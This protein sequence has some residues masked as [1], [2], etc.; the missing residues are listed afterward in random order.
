M[1]LNAKL[2]Q[3]VAKNYAK[4]LEE[5]DSCDVSIT[6]GS[7]DDIKTFNV[8]S[9]ILRTQTPYFHTA[10]SAQWGKKKGDKIVLS[11]PNVTPAIFEDILKFIYSSELKLD[12]KDVQHLLGL[13]SASDELILPV[14]S[15]HVQ[16]YL[17]INQA[18]WI[19]EHPLET[20]NAAFQHE[21]WKELQNCCVSTICKNPWML[22]ETPNFYHLD[23]SIL[24]YIIKKDELQM[25]ESDIWYHI[26]TWGIMQHA[27]LPDDLNEYTNEDFN[28]LKKT[29]SKFLPVIR[30]FNMSLEDFDTKVSPYRKIFP[31]ELYEDIL[32]HF[33]KPDRPKKY[34]SSILPKRHHPYANSKFIKTNYAKIT[35][36][37]TSYSKYATKPD[38]FKR[39]MIGP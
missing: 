8:H 5:E 4:L 37:K 10:F 25:E 33:L 36:Y 38:A 9:L 13:L 15:D 17:A 11:K 26:L 31:D 21:S 18:S 19:K 30:F 16:K 32:W 7:G 1:R 35:A 29:L 28:N 24:L 27:D 20:L 12:N 23:E 34:I 2:W 22:F 6:V 3:S 39:V 14:L